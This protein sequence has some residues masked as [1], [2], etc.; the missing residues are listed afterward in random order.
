MRC[1]TSFKYL[2]SKARCPKRM[3]NKNTCGLRSKLGSNMISEIMKAFLHS[4]RSTA[5]QH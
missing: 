3:A 5:Q 4:V 1:G 2:D